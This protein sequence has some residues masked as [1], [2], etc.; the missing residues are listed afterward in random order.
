MNMADSTGVF[1]AQAPWPPGVRAC[2]SLRQGGVSAAPFDSFNLGDHVGDEPACVR[3]NRQLWAQHTAAQPF[4]LKQVH[5]VDV[6]RLQAAVPT[7][8]TPPLQADGCWTDQPGVV[9]TMMVADCLPIL[10]AS[11]DGSSV[12]AV[13]AGW[14]GLAG[15]GGSLG[16]LES[17]CAQWPAAFAPQSRA[18]MVVWLGPCIGPQAFE[19]GPEVRAAFLA[20]A[21]TSA[22][23]QALAACFTLQAT[24]ALQ[25]TKYLA[26]LS[27]LARWRLQVLGFDRMGGNDGTLD[28]CTVSNPSRFFSHRRD[29]AVL[30]STGRMAAGIWRI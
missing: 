12:A 30:G 14:R 11:A 13:H 17:L 26:N 9:C 20:A 2:M 22:D 1:Q 28:W 8:S 7:P 25:P 3:A 19:V 18:N 5:G 10:L 23:E 4:F 27:A 29:A 16:V 15:V 6:V 24:P 21:R